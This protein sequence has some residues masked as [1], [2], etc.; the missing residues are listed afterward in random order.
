MASLVGYA[1]WNRLLEKHPASQVAPFT[2]L[3]PPV[4]ILAAWSLLGERLTTTALGG[5][6]L[7]VAGV[8]LVVLGRSVGRGPAD[9]APAS[10]SS[11]D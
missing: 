2:L 8:M 11:D 10:G 7:L 6:I 1:V 9:G 5:G 3:V 4:G